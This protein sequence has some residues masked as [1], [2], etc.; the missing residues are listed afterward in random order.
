[1]LIRSAS[2]RSALL[3]PL[4]ALLASPAAGQAVPALD[5]CTPPAALTDLVGGSYCGLAGGLYDG[6]NAMPAAHAAEGAAETAL[7]R[8]LDTAGR[9]DASGRIVLLSVGMS[10]ATQEWCGPNTTG[11]AGAT[12][13][14]PWTFKGQ[15]D[16]DAGVDHTALAV[17]NGAMGGQALNYWDA[18]DESN[19]DRVR[20]EVLAPDGLT[21]AQVQAVWLKA[22]LLDEPTRPGLPSDR[23]DAYALERAIGNVLRAFRVRYPNLRLVFV[24]SRIFSYARPGVGNSPEPY[25]YETGF[26]TRAAIEA[27]IRQRDGAG[28]DPVAGDLGPAAAPWMAWGPYL[29][30]PG[31][32]ARAD[33]L[34]WTR[35]LFQSD[36]VHPNTA[37]ETLVADSLLAFFKTS[38]FTRPWFVAG[39]T[40]TETSPGAS[41]VR[42]AVWPTPARGAAAVRLSLDAPSRVDVTLVDALGRLVARLAQGDQAAGD[43]ILALPRGLAPGVYVVRA[44]VGDHAVSRL[45]TVAR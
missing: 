34:R 38:P 8:P 36:G 42:L 17:A 23:A 30:A 29:W 33:G 24:T 5:F 12:P 15:A 32:S 21:E 14:N 45:V 41:G 18:P 37:G 35:D 6:T 43:L 13:C 1:M 4:A 44:V 26:G 3:L 25:A 2:V 11:A 39:A 19:Y 22:A 20:D 27:Q 10:N 28:T 7:V 40:A 9:P 31:D 16:A